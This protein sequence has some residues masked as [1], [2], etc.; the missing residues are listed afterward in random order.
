VPTLTDKVEHLVVL[1]LENRSFDHLLGWLP[2]PDP[3]FGGLTGREDNPVDPRDPDGERVTVARWDEGEAVDVDPGHDFA[4]V[5]EQLYG[6]RRAWRRSAGETPTNGGFLR[7]HA[8][9]AGQERAGDVMRCM[10]PDRVPVLARLALE[11][12]VF[13]RWFASVPGA[14]WPNRLFVHAATSAGT[15]DNVLGWY[16]LD[17]V[18]HRME[19][20]GIPW[21]VYRD[22]ITQVGAFVGLPRGLDRF[23]PF[24]LFLDDAARGRLPAYAFIEP[25]HFP[26]GKN[27]QH[28]VQDLAHGELLVARVYRA[29]RASP[30]WPR[31]ALLLVWDEHGGFFDHVP[32]PATVAPDAR[33]AARYPSFAFARLGPRVPAVLVSPWIERGTVD[34]GVRDHT[35]I[36]ASLRRRFGLGAPLGRRDAGALDVW[37][38]LR[39]DT[40]RADLVEVDPRPAGAVA[41][42][43]EQLDG[44]QADL[45]RLAQ[46]FEADR[47]QAA[48]RR[49]AGVLAGRPFGSR[50]RHAPAYRRF[51]DALEAGAWV[52]ATGDG[53]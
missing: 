18:F 31:A 1:V 19:R 34:H 47:G 9:R 12:C 49:A 52:R 27:S 21:R 46:Q 6:R 50:F 42:V 4:D 20:A 51:A 29:L 10:T 2:H 24:E 14:T 16:R 41:R 5:M 38:A 43:N 40:P 33:R 13:D 3:S 30:A 8:R 7:V 32:P 37:G 15:V 22:G 36:V 28:P 45:V 17:T 11:Y 35:A 23:A 39:R 48:D 26:P 53:E 25:D 44:L